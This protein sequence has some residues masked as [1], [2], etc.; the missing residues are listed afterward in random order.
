LEILAHLDPLVLERELITRVASAH[1]RRPDAATLVLVPTERLADH[2]QRRLAAERRAWIGLE[3]LHLRRFARRVLDGSPERSPRVASS[4]LLA[5]LLRRLLAERQER[6]WSRSVDRFPGTLHRLQRVMNELREAGVG[7]EELL[8]CVEKVPRQLELGQLYRA[9]V[10]ALNDLRLA[11]WVDEAG[12]IRAATERAGEH[13]GRYGAIFLHGAYEWIGVHVDL[14]HALDR[15]VGVT[16]C[17]P[18][19][20]GT[21]VSAYSMAF[22]QEFLG[23]EPEALDAPP[24]EAQRFDLAAL[25]DE[26]RRPRPVPAGRCAFRHAQGEPA[27]VRVAVREALRAVRDGCPPTE[28]VITARSLEPYA[29]ALEE[30]FEDEQI[31]WTSS[32]K[33]PLRRHPA[34]R[35]FLL[36][37]RV[38]A[39]DFP[40]G[41]TAELLRSPR[42]QWQH[43][44]G[45]AGRPRGE[46]ADVWSRKARIVGGLE[47]WT[48]QLQAWAGELLHDPEAGEEERRE[49]ER[50][51]AGRLDSARRIG[52]ALQAL[53]DRV[54]PGSRTWQQHA[55]RLRELLDL[56]FD[57]GS[58]ETAADGLNKLRGLLDEMAQLES[59]AGNTG[60]VR[61]S[62]AWRWLD[63]AVDGCELPLRAEDNGGIRV[64]DAMQLRGLTFERVY[65]LGLNSGLFPR[66][67]RE[68]PILDDAMRR[69]LRERSGRPLP[70]KSRGDLEE[71]LLLG[72]LLGAAG[73]RIE[74]SWQR[75]DEAGKAKTPS[76]A[77]RE[78]SRLVHG[79]PALGELLEHARHLPSHPKHWLERMVE[80]PGLLAPGEAILLGALQAG[81]CRDLE[82]L[83]RRHPALAAGV[84]MLRATQSFVI[85][86]PGYD[87]R[88]GPWSAAGPLSVS[89]LR[90]LG[91]CPLKFFFERVL[92][93]RELDD[94][95]SLFELEAR[96]IGIGVHDLLERIYGVLMREK[97]FDAAEPDALIERAVELLAQEQGRMLG[98]NDAR[99]SRRLPVMR[100]YLRELWGDAVRAF[101]EWDLDRL[102]RE[103]W[104]PTGFETPVSEPL[105][106][107][108]GVVQEV[109]GRFDR[110]LH[111]E[112]GDVVADY[113]TSG[114]LK[115]QINPTGMLRGRELQVPLYRM[116]A[117]DGARV[118]LLG[119]GPRFDEDGRCFGFD[120]FE[121]P[122]E[123]PGF[124]E[125]MRILLRLARG[126]SFP[127]YV[128]RPC[129]WC[130]YAQACRHHHPPTLA[131]N[132]QFEDSRDFRDVQRKTRK[133]P[134]LTDVRKSK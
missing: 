82:P 108:D 59:F 69:R 23:Q 21:P 37:L 105:D 18:A 118:E 109:Q 83:G 87:A 102:C 46:T 90:T 53:R 81:A 77:L 24:E 91:A 88:T 1:P 128:D 78:V 29:P 122:G 65:A 40:R 28:I 20:P 8:A 79:A 50:R 76:L 57:A 58:E 114:D 60:Q 25:Y 115:K 3:V 97:L 54:E 41:P 7:P 86:D 52:H 70:L 42:L 19:L 48:R 30:L 26:A 80:Q 36:A 85:V 39:E 125:T 133:I 66:P 16:A 4:R 127:M 43:V 93:V 55:A 73:E 10:A 61:F 106:L 35:D 126:G 9:Y 113:K 72:L 68:D 84:T 44:A 2:L 96:E 134:T 100:D 99:L 101:L 120:G 94:Q 13:A 11:G 98:A 103:G 22:A 27:E 89:A 119:V 75:A 131:R 92:R 45:K 71:R 132:I 123:G 124:R 111:G 74:I 129:D 12:L 63:D 112:H 31:P 5:A 14:I 51:A 49:A 6:T 110:L 17:I 15:S 107:G 62:E 67:P 117:G 47:E 95:A 56:L 34:V 32:L 116:L 130:P 38:L 33:T 104:Q 121:T 64:L